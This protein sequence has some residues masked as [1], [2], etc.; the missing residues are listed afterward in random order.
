MHQLGRLSETP[1]DAG[2]Y[3][4]HSTGHARRAL[5]DRAAGSPH[6]EVVVAELEPGGSVDLHVHAFE[7]AFYV[8]EGRLTFEAAGATEEL[9]PDD[10]EGAP[11]LENVEGF[12]ER[13]NMQIDAATG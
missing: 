12:L 11:P 13:V 10:F 7:E 3:A 5:I 2:R 4:G 9:G 6:Q 1:A 8:L